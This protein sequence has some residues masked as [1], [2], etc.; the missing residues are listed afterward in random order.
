MDTELARTFI[1]VVAAGS[2]VE[3]ANRLHVTQSTV[4]TRI[5]R[6]EEKLGAELFVRNKSGTT[7]TPAGRQFQRH[8]ALLTR[9]VELAR[10]EIGIVSGFR[11]TLTVGARVGL[12]EDL[13]SIWLPIFASRAPD[14]AVRALVGFEEDLMQ[15]LIDGQANIAVMYTP[16]TRPG[17]TV[18]PLLEEQLVMI[19][20]QHDPPRGPARDYI[21][22]DWGPEFFTQHQLAFPNFIGAALTVNVGWLGLQHLLLHGGT[23]YFP[24]RMLREHERRGRVH[25]VPGAPE[26]RLSAYL[27]FS[28]EVDSEALALA[29]DSIRRVAA[30]VA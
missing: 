24:V 28:T 17:L 7:L 11:A 8:A 29:L 30:E 27:V 5:Q 4:S 1:V 16:Q 10:Q 20:T 22:V 6:L 3:A 13:L 26:F 15:A 19:S 18:E 23:G 12:W 2:F 21:Y 9:T 25:R 14:V